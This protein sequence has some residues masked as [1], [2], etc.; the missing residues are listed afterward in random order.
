MKSN[1]YPKFNIL[2]LDGRDIF[3]TSF[4][5]FLDTVYQLSSFVKQEDG[6]VSIPMSADTKDI[7]YTCILTIE[8]DIKLL[9]A[10]LKDKNIYCNI[11][12]YFNLQDLEQSQ[13][14]FNYIDKKFVHTQIKRALKTLIKK[15]IN[16]YIYNASE[17]INFTEEIKIINEPAG[18]IKEVLNII[19][20]KLS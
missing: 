13:E 6:Q 3:S 15:K 9:K 11:I 20:F 5:C 10:T 2:L 7:L 17:K 12:I 8:K 19:N 1:L 14:I 4:V 16:Y 18:K